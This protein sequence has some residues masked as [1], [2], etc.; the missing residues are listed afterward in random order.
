MKKRIVILGCISLMTIGVQC[1]SPK[2]VGNKTQSEVQNVVSIKEQLAKG[3]FLVD[4][5]TKE[6]FDAGSVKGA[7]N[8][9]LYDIE[10]RLNDFKGKPYVILFCR[11]GHRAGIAKTMLENHG[12]TNITNG[13]NADHIN[14]ELT[15]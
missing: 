2:L 5:R 14:A 8:I 1:H 6:E 3:A 15:K 12:I 7:V 4:V 13:I 11:S 9:P 10:S